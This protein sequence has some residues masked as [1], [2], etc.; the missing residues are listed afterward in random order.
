MKTL[1]KFILLAGCIFLLSFTTNKEKTIIVIDAGH[2]GND[3]GA[4]I[5]IHSEKEIVAA[6]T[7]KILLLN[8]HSNI[9]IHTTRTTDQ[10]VSL[11][12]RVAVINQIKPDLVIS[13]HTNR[14][15]NEAINGM[16][17][18][19]FDQSNTYIQSQNL[20]VSLLN[21]L[22][23]VTTLEKRSIKTAPFYILK[24][25][26]APAILVELGFL[27]NKNDLNYLTNE[28]NQSKIALGILNFVSTIKKNRP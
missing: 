14:S 12:E 21:E 15:K 11:Q 22:T 2:G 7:N 1:L 23:E 16:E 27:S 13:L 5:D 9:E 25:T 3:F 26:E 10:L 6:I 17:C 24:N 20:A 19:V 8:P 4:V 28:D 18:F